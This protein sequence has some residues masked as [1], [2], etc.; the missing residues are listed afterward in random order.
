MSRTK[1][2]IAAAA[3]TVCLAVM[4][5]AAHDDGFRLHRP[6]YIETS[7]DMDGLDCT[8][9]MVYVPGGNPGTARY[10][11]YWYPRAT[12]HVRLVNEDHVNW[13]LA[14]YRTYDPRS[15]TFVGKGYRH[16][17]CDSPYD[18]V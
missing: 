4:P 15:N 10:G 9:R 14:R 11:S 8:A 17:R 5:A 16:Y 1:T 7:C 18:G 13:C 12:R 3:A 2:V 6:Y